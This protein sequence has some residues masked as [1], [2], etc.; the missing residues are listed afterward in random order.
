MVESVALTAKQLDVVKFIVSRSQ[1]LGR[2]IGT[3]DLCD[4]FDWGSRDESGKMVRFNL[5][6]ASTH[7]KAI[8]R[9]TGKTLITWENCENGDIKPNSLRAA[10][11]AAVSRPQE[12]ANCRNGSGWAVVV[13][14]ENVAFTI[15]TENEIV[16]HDILAVE[17]ALEFCEMF[18]IVGKTTIDRIAK[19]AEKQA[20]MAAARAA[21]VTA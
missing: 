12:S 9:K 14:G 4:N 2:G 8:R 6:S 18:K 1:E 16:K 17:K 19:L 20:T 13:V 3:R 21:K 7:L 5:N 15:F 11:M 10:D